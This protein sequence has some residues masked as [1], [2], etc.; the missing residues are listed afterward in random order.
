MSVVWWVGG[1]SE[2]RWFYQLQGS[3]QKKFQAG[4]C[5]KDQSS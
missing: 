5:F 4:R 2:L 1:V 3:S